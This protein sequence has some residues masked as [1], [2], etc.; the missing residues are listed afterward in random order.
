[1]I[2]GGLALPENVAVPA[3]AGK[4]PAP[5]NVAEMSLVFVVVADAAAAVPVVVAVSAAAPADVVA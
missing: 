5:T 2:C 3:T 4:P 1:M